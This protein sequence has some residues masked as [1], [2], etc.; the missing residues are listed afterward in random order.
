MTFF[1]IAKLTPQY[2]NQF[3]GVVL[4]RVTYDVGFCY[5]F[6]IYKQKATSVAVRHNGL[7]AAVGEIFNAR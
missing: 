3:P 7:A 1:L 4:Q 6:K 2:N 5:E